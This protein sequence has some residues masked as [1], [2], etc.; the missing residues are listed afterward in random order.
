VC[1]LLGSPAVISHASP[2]SST[3]LA[4]EQD[5]HNWPQGAG[6]GA[7]NSLCCSRP[8]QGA[9]LGALRG[10]YR[11]THNT[12]AGL[13]HPVQLHSLNTRA[14]LLHPMCGSTPTQG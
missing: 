14:G 3:A 13:R 9:E 2:S 12:R 1:L 5:V 10:W 6:A 7:C 11:P 8:H 4:A